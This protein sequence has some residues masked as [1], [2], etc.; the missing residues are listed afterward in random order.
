MAGAVE[1][2]D[3]GLTEIGDTLGRGNPGPALQPGRERL[4]EQPGAELCRQPGRGGEPV[5]TGS[6]AP[7]EDDCRLAG[8]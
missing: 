5:G 6:V 1:L 7:D 3:G 2:S 8:A 4:A